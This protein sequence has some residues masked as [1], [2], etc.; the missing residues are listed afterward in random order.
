MNKFGDAEIKLV[1]ILYSYLAELEIKFK[2]IIT[3]I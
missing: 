1:Q 3:V 2:F